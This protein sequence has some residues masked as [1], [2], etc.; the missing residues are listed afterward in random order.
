MNQVRSDFLQRL[1]QSAI[2]SLADFCFI[3][4]VDKQHLR[5]AASAH[6]TRAGRRLVRGLARSD[7]II[8]TDPLSTVAQAVRSRRPQVRTEIA[9]DPDPPCRLRVFDLHRQLG[10]QSAIV[11]P[12]L[13]GA[14]ALGALTLGYADSGRQYSAQDVSWATRLARQISGR[15]SRARDAAAARARPLSRASAATTRRLPPLRARA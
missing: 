8:C 14:D 10:A 13:D 6:V 2:P 3:H 5:C 11:V 9:R 7:R 4:L 15:L 1:A 12:L